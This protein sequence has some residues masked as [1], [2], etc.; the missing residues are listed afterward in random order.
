M[1]QLRKNLTITHKTIDLPDVLKTK[2]SLF[3]MIQI[4]FYV[5]IN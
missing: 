4:V 2:F 5:L 1:L 3:L